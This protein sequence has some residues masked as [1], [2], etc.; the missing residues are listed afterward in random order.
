MEDS[1]CVLGRPLDRN[2]TYRVGTKVYLLQGKDGYGSFA[3][4]RSLPLYWMPPMHAS[5]AMRLSPCCNLSIPRAA[6]RAPAASQA[7]Q[8]S[9]TVARFLR[10]LQRFLVFEIFA[11]L[12]CLD[13]SADQLR[14]CGDF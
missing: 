10:G 4:V 13:L 8:K 1:V 11:V 14:L 9:S 7:L 3:D 12:R 2:I 6:S 5:T